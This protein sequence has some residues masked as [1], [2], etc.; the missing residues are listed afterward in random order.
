MKT[1]VTAPIAQVRLNQ[2]PYKTEIRP[3]IIKIM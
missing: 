3:D 2:L 1:A